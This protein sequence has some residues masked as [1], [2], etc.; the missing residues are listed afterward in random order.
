MTILITDTLTSVKNE[1][2]VYNFFRF[3]VGFNFLISPAIIH[4]G[5][6]DQ[7]CKCPLSPIDTGLES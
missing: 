6:R 3:K 4:A 5:K 2:K 7:G 1:I